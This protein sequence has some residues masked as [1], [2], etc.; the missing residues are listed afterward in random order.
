ME[1]TIRLVLKIALLHADA[2]D[3]STTKLTTPAAAA[4]PTAANTCTNGLS[5]GTIALHG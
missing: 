4:I 5:V 1:Y 2:A 3:V